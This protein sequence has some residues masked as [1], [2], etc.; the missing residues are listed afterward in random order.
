MGDPWVELVETVAERGRKYQARMDKRDATID[1]DEAATLGNV[2][3]NDGAVERITSAYVLWKVMG[4]S[5][6]QQT[7]EHRKRLG[8]AM[9]KFGWRGPDILWIGGRA[10]RGYERDVAAPTREEWDME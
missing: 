3:Q 10:A 7:P 1:A 6:A 9:R 4:I 8:V 2:Y 5:P